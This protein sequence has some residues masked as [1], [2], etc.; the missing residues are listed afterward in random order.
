MNNVEEKSRSIGIFGHLLKAWRRSDNVRKVKVDLP[1]RDLPRIRGHIDACLNLKGGEVTARARAVELGQMYLGLSEEGRAR[2]LRLLAEEYGAD[3]HRLDIAM[4]AMQSANGSDERQVAARELRMALEPRRVTLLRQ[5]NAL[6]E[7]VK[8]LVDMRTD[9]LDLVRENKIYRPLEADLK[10]LLASWFDIG[11]LELR[12]ITWESSAALLEK[13]IAYEA[14]HTIKSWDD[15]KDR[16][17]ADRR[18]FAFFHPRMPDEPLIFVEVALVKGI[19]GN[20]HDLLDENTPPL[21]ADEAD[22]AIFY[23]ISNAQPGLA[24]VSFGNF[25]IKRVVSELARDIPNIKTYSTLSPVPGYVGWLDNVIDKG[26]IDTYLTA[27]EVASLNAIASTEVG[28]TPLR[29]LL[30]QPN[31]YDNETISK[32]V[33]PILIRLCGH[34]LLQAKR[35]RR[36]LD[37]VA[38]FHLTNGARLE[39][40]NLRGNLSIDGLQQSAGLMVNYLYKLNDIDQNHEAYA[41][42]GEI[43]A[44]SAIQRMVR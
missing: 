24:G 12:Q 40:I 37:P 26:K 6:P 22:T 18:C 11:F 43:K 31:W 35:G 32:L 16:L 41:L 21:N 33:E 4:M 5:F 2:F 44:A 10:D 30:A 20:V 7:G 39:R 34:Y 27:E 1:D 15:L 14:V 36:A 19:A 3:D 38:H 17:D 42:N 29:R 23:S 28:E 13:L 9:I 25:L 8:F